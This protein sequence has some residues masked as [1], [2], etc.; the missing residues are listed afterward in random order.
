LCESELTRSRTPEYLDIA[1]RLQPK[2]K[3]VAFYKPHTG[4]RSDPAQDVLIDL[5]EVGYRPKDRPYIWR[6]LGMV[7]VVVNYITPN[8]AK[9]RVDDAKVLRVGEN[10]GRSGWGFTHTS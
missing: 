6:A 4:S 9:I 5:S 3:L 10:C 7:K 8:H 2:A 1:I